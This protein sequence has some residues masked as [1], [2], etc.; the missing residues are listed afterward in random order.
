MA[1]ILIVDDEAQ[2]R[3]LIRTALESGGHAVFEA[4]DAQSALDI[5]ETYP[6]PFDMIILDIRMP[7]MDGFEFLSILQNQ[8]ICPPVII[9]SAH[10]GE[11]PPALAK[12]VIGRF[13]KPFRRQELNDTVNSF[14]AVT[15]T[16]V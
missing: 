8:P 2:I 13:R 11:I 9:L 5:L 16:A 10:S 12:M 15:T 14:L 3:F 1:H 4:R 7:D 6:D